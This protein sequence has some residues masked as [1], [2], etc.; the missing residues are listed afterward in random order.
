M[1]SANVNE[2]ASSATPEA[3]VMDMK[4]EVVML[5]VTDVDKAKR[6]YQNSGW[7]PDADIL[8]GGAFRRCS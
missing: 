5:P 3:R 7:R 1:S 8:R 2:S 6:F 4:L